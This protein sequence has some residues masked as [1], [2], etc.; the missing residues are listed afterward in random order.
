[1]QAL[2]DYLRRLQWPTVP[3]TRSITYVEL[4]LDYEVAMGW[5]SLLPPVDP[6]KVRPP[7]WTGHAALH[8]SCVWPEKRRLRHWST[9][10][11]TKTAFTAWRPSGFRAPPG[12]PDVLYFSWWEATELLLQ[13]LATVCSQRLT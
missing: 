10:V 11:S 6:L 12:S 2:L 13:Q 3:P 1:M 7:L 9:P 4:A 8:S 5:I